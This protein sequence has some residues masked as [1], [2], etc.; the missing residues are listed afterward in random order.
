[1]GAEDFIRVAEGALQG[2][3]EALLKS[4]QELDDLPRPLFKVVMEKLRERGKELFPLLPLGDGV[5]LRGEVVASEIAYHHSDGDERQHLVLG[6][7]VEKEGEK[8]PRMFLREV[9]FRIQPQHLQKAARRIL[10]QLLSETPKE[11]LRVVEALEGWAEKTRGLLREVEA[12]YATALE[13]EKEA[14]EALKLRA[15]IRGLGEE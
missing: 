15:A 6:L 7:F 9:V 3:L 10:S 1:M 14:L 4:V 13:R 12:E 2:A 11:A 5:V 8:G